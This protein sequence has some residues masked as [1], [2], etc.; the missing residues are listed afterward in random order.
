MLA[1]QQ[2][3]I[4]EAGSETQTPQMR[5]SFLQ[6][7]HLPLAEKAPTSSLYPKNFPTLA[8]SWE[9]GL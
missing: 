7:L 2:Q 6:M 3:T 9:K 8:S 4:L 1:D 5:K